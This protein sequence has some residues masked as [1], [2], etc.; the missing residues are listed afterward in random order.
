M[1]NADDGAELIDAWPLRLA[2][3]AAQRAEIVNTVAAPADRV[4]EA[5]AGEGSV[6]EKGESIAG[7]RPTLR[8]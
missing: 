6:S 8:P 5:V 1:G 4:T 3:R 2:M 7:H